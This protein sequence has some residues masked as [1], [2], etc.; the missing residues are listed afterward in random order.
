M[1]NKVYV[2]ITTQTGYDDCDSISDIVLVTTNRKKA[3][4]CT[5]ILDSLSSCISIPDDEATKLK[6]LLKQYKIDYDNLCPYE[7]VDYFERKIID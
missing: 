5:R 1:K 6:K 7:D 2:V 4:D 3:E